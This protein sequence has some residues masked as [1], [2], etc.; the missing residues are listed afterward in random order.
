[1]NEDNS[2]ELRLSRLEDDVKGLKCDDKEQCKITNN[3][4]KSIIKSEG[5]QEKIFSMLTYVSKDITENKITL[6]ENSK[7]S[8]ATENL[9]L[10]LKSEALS[11]RT[12][13]E[14]LSEK[15]AEIEEAPKK[16]NEKLKWL[17]IT[18]ILSN[19]VGV[20]SLIYKAIH[21]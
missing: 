4:E 17:L 5:V 16:N 8:I 18:F 12:E 2:V 14:K 3:V 7:R 20:I 11:L 19:I 6:E 10:N 9:A 21:K 13:V 15:I 1:M